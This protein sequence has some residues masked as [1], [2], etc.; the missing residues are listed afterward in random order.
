MIATETPQ[1]QRYSRKKKVYSSGEPSGLGFG[2]KNNLEEDEEPMNEEAY[3]EELNEIEAFQEEA[4][5]EEAD[6]APADEPEEANN[7]VM[8]DGALGVLGEDDEEPIEDEEDG[9]QVEVVM[10]E[11]PAQ[12][13][14]NTQ[15]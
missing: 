1:R 6:G 9:E 3:K 7:F 10:I 11:D 2:G 8:D 4:E 13:A 14:G 5:A 12:T 15:H